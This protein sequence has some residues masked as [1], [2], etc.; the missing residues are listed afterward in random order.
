M[1]RKRSDP[2]LVRRNR[3]IAERWYHWTEVER[4]RFDDVLTILEEKE[5]FIRKAHLLKIIREHQ[6]YIDALISGEE[7]KDET[8]NPNQLK[9]FNNEQTI[10]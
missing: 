3:K 2:L 10:N 8:E 4:R 5:F 7:I 1:G 6:D 9:L